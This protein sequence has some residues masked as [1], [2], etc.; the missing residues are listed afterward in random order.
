MAA[1]VKFVLAYVAEGVERES[2]VNRRG[3]MEAMRK[4]RRNSPRKGVE[5]ESGVNR[6]G[7]MEA[8]RTV[9]RHSPRKASMSETKREQEKEMGNQE[10]Q[11]KAF[12]GTV[13]YGG[14]E[15]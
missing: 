15:G 10:K 13:R 12:I 6:R 5:R 7:K 9:R 1:N 2:G 3:E 4:V 8:M 14:R 11:R